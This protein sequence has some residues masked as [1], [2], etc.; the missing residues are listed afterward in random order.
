MNGRLMTNKNT[1]KPSQVLF[2]AL[3]LPYGKRAFLHRI[4]DSAEVRG[5]NGAGFTKKQP[6]DYIVTFDGDTHFA[7]V[8]STVGARFKRSQIES[9]Q[10]AAAKQQ[11][12]AGGHYFFYVHAK[13]I[14]QWFRVPGDFVLNSAKASW[15]WLDLKGFR[16]Q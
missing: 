3:F 8:K 16:F 14:G 5:M 15:S 4:T 1:G 9:G 12:A 13:A 6:A 7:E 11:I 2:E 10:E